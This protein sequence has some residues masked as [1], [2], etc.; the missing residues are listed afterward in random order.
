[1]VHKVRRYE[2]VRNIS[3]GDGRL[4]KGQLVYRF[5]AVQKDEVLI[6]LR[7]P[8]FLSPRDFGSWRS[9]AELSYGL[10]SGVTTVFSAAWFEDE[11]DEK[12]TANSGIRTSIG[13]FSLEADVAATQDGAHALSGGIGG[14]LG[15]SFFTLSHVEYSGLFL[16]ETRSTSN[17]FLRRTTELSFNNRF[18]LGKQG[19]R[20]LDIPIST[21]LLRFET[22]DGLERIAA[23][24][25]ASIWLPR[26]LLSNS[27]EY[28]RTSR[29]GLETFSQLNGSFDLSTLSQS[30]TKVRASANYTIQPRLRFVSATLNLDH[31]VDDLTMVRGSLGYDFSSDAAQISVSGRRQFDRFSL[32]VYGNY[33]FV[34]DS[35]SFGLRMGL[36]VGRE[37]I[38]G[39]FFLDAENSLA[40]T[41]SASILAFHDRD[42]DGR[43]GEHDEPVP[44]VTFAAFNSTTKSNDGGVARLTGLRNGRPINIK[45]DEKTLPDIDLAMV[46]LGVEVVPR[47]GRIHVVEMPI[48]ALSEVE[49]TAYLVQEESRRAV[50]GVRLEL[51]DGDGKSVAATRT[52]LDGYYFFERVQPG[53]YDIVINI[54]QVNRLNICLDQDY[55]VSIGHETEILSVDVKI[56][57]CLP[58]AGS[59]SGG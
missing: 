17:D 18:S 25:Q 20:R 38:Q 55:P 23:S 9:I 3:V 33:T 43:F 56:V 16:D 44:G 31:L 8:E 42:G 26:M 10:S 47:A 27:L 6:G 29:T 13:R 30:R 24:L 22:L 37:P 49:G 48:I 34:R 57:P 40:N 1:M 21:R 7:D 52:E 35:Y 59:D 4:P 50:S 14:A 46:S 28:L 15:Q 11:G 12:W 41:G 5:G 39:R 54:G 36:S 2:E 32:A 51:Q 53:T 58:A 45:A 19:E